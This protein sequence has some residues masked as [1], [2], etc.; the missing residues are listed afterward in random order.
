MADFDIE[1][2][3]T[4]VESGAVEAGPTFA[5][6]G[7]ELP[8]KAIDQTADVDRSGLRDAV[9]AACAGVRGK[10]DDRR[11]GGNR[12]EGE[13]KR[14]RWARDIARRIGLANVDGVFCIAAH[15]KARAATVGPVRTI[16]RV[17][18]SSALFQ[19]A[20]VDHAT[21]GDEV[22]ACATIAVQRKRRGRDRMVDADDH[23][24]LRHHLIA[25][26]IGLA[27]Q[28]MLVVT[29]GERVG[30]PCQFLERIASVDRDFPGR[31]VFEARDIDLA[32]G[33]YAIN[34]TAAGVLMQGQH[35][36]GRGGRVQCEG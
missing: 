35:R 16:G 6:V 3:I 14:F 17:L 28:Q 4:Q 36:G 29:L 9:S 33:G 13:G 31:A 5:A 19:A 25:G 2:S 18:P 10:L 23:Q 24:F 8:S 7:R 34:A 22:A 30:R 1:G 27:H 26:G 20:D 12:V 21:V 11:F 15:F 32:V